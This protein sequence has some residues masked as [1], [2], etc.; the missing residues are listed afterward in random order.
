[1][2]KTLILTSFRGNEGFVLLE[3]LVRIWPECAV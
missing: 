2:N 3:Y 1:M